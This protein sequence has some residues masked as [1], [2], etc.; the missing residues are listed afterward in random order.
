MARSDTIR[1]PRWRVQIFSPLG[2]VTH[3]STFKSL[4]R[5]KEYYDT[6][7]I[8]KSVK[9]LEVR[10]AGAKVHQPDKHGSRTG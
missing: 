1:E 6:L 2:E 7:V 3:E 8:A 10:A 4:D 5:A 9:R